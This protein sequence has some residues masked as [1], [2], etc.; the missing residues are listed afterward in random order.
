MTYLEEGAVFKSDGGAEGVVA[1]GHTPAGPR[2]QDFPKVATLGDARLRLA[3]RRLESLEV[4]LL[5]HAHTHVRLK[6]EW[7]S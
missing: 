2:V 3:P 7:H 5:L 4:L 6:G 1:G